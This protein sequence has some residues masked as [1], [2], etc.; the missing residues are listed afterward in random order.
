MSHDLLSQ[1]DI[2]EAAVERIVGDA[3]DGA[4]DGELYC[5]FEETESLLFD[6]G[7]LKSGSYSTDRGFGLRSVSGTLS[8]RGI[9]SSCKPN[10]SFLRSKKIIN[11]C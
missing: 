7:R 6:N 10:F 11:F 4:E 8:S 2:D 1:F 9:L 3:L 5:E